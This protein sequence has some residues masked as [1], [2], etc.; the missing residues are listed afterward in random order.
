MPRYKKSPEERAA[1]K[2][3]REKI[4]NFVHE[5]GAEGIEDLHDVY[6][7]MIGAVVDGG[8]DAELDDQ[9]GYSKYDYRNKK[10]DNSRNGFSKKLLKQASV[11]LKFL[12]PEIETEIL[13]HRL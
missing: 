3:R 1:E 13:N 5:M 7:M 11:I 9:L 6:K 2:E 8:L 4:L 10:V 12:Y